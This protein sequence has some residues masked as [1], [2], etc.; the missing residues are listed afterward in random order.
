MELS[1]HLSIIIVY[2]KIFSAQ[3]L[4][5]D[6]ISYRIMYKFSLNNLY[7]SVN[8]D[9]LVEILIDNDVNKSV[10]L[11]QNKFIKII[12]SIVP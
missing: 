7:Q 8:V 9:N 11:L 4:H 5:P 10:E 2:N 1:D 3:P 6:K 12:I